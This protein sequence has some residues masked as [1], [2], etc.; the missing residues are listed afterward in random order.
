MSDKEEK[1]NNQKTDSPTI[2]I[3]IHDEQHLLKKKPER[4]DKDSAASKPET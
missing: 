4:E 2:E 1:D 3:D